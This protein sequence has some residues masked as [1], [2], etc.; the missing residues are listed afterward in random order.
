LT[1]DAKIFNDAL[2]EGMANERKSK[3][4]GKGKAVNN[5][6]PATVKGMFHALCLK[7]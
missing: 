4:K 1:G 5:D 2:E 7:V 3:G 6:K